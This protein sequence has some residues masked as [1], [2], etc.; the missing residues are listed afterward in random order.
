MRRE[1]REIGVAREP[2]SRVET[3]PREM[4][5]RAFPIPAFVL[6]NARQFERA[7]PF[8]GRFNPRRARERTFQQGLG[9]GGFLRG[10]ARQH[11]QFAA[12]R[13]SLAGGHPD[14]DPGGPR[15]GVHWKIAAFAPRRR[16]NR[17]RLAGSP[18]GDAS[19]LARQN[20]ATE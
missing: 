17:D 4:R 7:Y 9:R 8:R 6:A 16:Q 18:A 10:R 20:P 15:G 3:Q 12:T 2:D 1:Q 19:P 14:L 5:D 13:Q 11:P